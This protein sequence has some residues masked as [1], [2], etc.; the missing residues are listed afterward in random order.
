M[1]DSWY[2]L[3]RFVPEGITQVSSRSEVGNTKR[4]SLNT[5]LSSG[6]SEGTFAVSAGPT[7][8]IVPKQVRKTNLDM[9]LVPFQKKGW[10][11]LNFYRFVVRSEPPRY[12]VAVR[13]PRDSNREFC[14]R[15]RRRSNSSRWSHRTYTIHEEF[16]DNVPRGLWNEPNLNTRKEG[17]TKKESQSSIKSGREEGTGLSRLH[18]NGGKLH[19]NREI[20]G[21]WAVRVWVHR[22]TWSGR[23]L[24]SVLEPN[25]NAQRLSLLSHLLCTPW[26]NLGKKLLQ[27]PA[28]FLINRVPVPSCGW[29][30]VTFYGCE[31]CDV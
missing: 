18:K 14:M 28:Q 22:D 12:V 17:P 5:R 15:S 8:I 3:D 4:R 16:D 26:A 30:F 31:S 20:V 10:L 19:R 11:Y 24:V 6:T 25:T 27:L 13:I 2:C 21:I 29:R 7:E 1:V 9:F 23:Q